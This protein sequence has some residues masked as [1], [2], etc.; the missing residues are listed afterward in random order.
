MLR[1]ALLPVLIGT[2]LAVSGCQTTLPPLEPTT[3]I[4]AFSDA[5]GEGHFDLPARYVGA[6]DAA[7]HSSFFDPDWGDDGFCVVV[8][9]GSRAAEGR[10]FVAAYARDEAGS[11]GNRAGFFTT[12]GEP[13]ILSYPEYRRHLLILCHA[14]D[15]CAV[16]RFYSAAPSVA[17]PNVF[18]TLYLR[19]N[20]VLAMQATDDGTCE[21]LGAGQRGG[22]DL[23]AFWGHPEMRIVLDHGASGMFDGFGSAECF[24]EI[25]NG[26]RTDGGMIFHDI[27][28]VEPA[29]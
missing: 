26:R 8:N 16:Q 29:A 19:G 20:D 15:T 22:E 12:P 4:S 18:G 25:I 5:R 2:G 13:V 3:G 11:L 9:A 28:G 6:D 1:H 17:F 21:I 24:V 10:V 27:G 23:G 7:C 14:D